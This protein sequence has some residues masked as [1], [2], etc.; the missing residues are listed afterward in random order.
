MN[1]AAIKVWPVRSE[2]VLNNFINRAVNHT[3]LNLLSS[4]TSISDC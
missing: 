3:V 4:I 1:N 2:R